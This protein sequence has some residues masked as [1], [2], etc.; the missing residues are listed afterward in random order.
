MKINNAF[1]AENVKHIYDKIH[2]YGKDT[3][4]DY[5]SDESIHYEPRHDVNCYC[6]DKLNPLE[7]N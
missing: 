5:G 2:L 6:S 7:K 3:G 4:S 1:S